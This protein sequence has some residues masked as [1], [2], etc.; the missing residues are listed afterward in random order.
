M[1]PDSPRRSHRVLVT[2]L[3]V[4]GI[5]LTPITIVALFANTQISDTNR[6]VQNVAPLSSDPAVQAYVADDVTNR[7]LSEVDVAAYVRDALPDRAQR[8]AGPIASALQGFVHE[9]TLRILQSDQFQVFWEQANRFA[10]AQLVKVLTGN[11]NGVVNQANNGVV[12]LDL[13]AVA[14]RVQERLQASGLD[15]FSKL[16]IAKIGGQIPVFQ[17]QDLYKARR[18]VGA[19]DKVAFVLPFVV[20]ACFA[21]AV[22]LSRDRRR[23]FVAAALCFGFGAI[24]LGIAL[25]VLR[26]VYLD[27]ATSAELPHDAAAAVYDTLVRFLHTSVRAA[28]TFSVFVVLAAFF[29][30]PSRLAAGFRVDAR[31]SAN[32]LGDRSDEAGWGWLGAST[33]VVHQKTKLR[34]LT[35]VVAF[36]IAIVWSRPTPSVLFWI[37]VATLAALALVEFFGREPL[38]AHVR[39][40]ESEAAHVPAS[41]PPAP[42]PR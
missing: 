28:L 38:P 19:L 31:R 37:A 6:Y 23:G 20:L 10:H 4:V 17:S 25:N 13:S 35:A 40:T 5:V 2:L 30:G 26:N 42:V 18:A 21:A 9:T 3:L 7:L 32:W 33:F 22:W 8:L 1:T 12:T 11:G 29:A 41:T 27:A 36:A 16:P 24:V 14:A 39:L 15:L 34:V